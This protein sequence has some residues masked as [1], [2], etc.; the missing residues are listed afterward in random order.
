MCLVI[1]THDDKG[2]RPMLTVDDAGLLGT[3]VSFTAA[4]EV[5]QGVS[6]G[7]NGGKLRL[8]LLL[9]RAEGFLGHAQIR[10]RLTKFC[11][12]CARIARSD[13]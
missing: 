9:V 3:N 10:D 1:T 7:G 6:P 4:A 5:T 12:V 11:D 8:R 2:D 13:G